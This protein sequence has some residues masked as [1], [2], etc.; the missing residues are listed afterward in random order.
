MDRHGYFL[1]CWY[2]HIFSYMF[3]HKN[4]NGCIDPVLTGCLLY[5]KFTYYNVLQCTTYLSPKKIEKYNPTQEWMV[6][7]L[8]Y[9]FG[10][11]IHGYP[12]ISA[13]FSRFFP[14][15]FRLVAG[16]AA[17]IREVAR[18][19]RTA[20]AMGLVWPP[21][22]SRAGTPKTRQPGGKWGNIDGIYWIYIY[23]N[24]YKLLSHRH[25]YI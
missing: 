21:A 17:F 16:T 9:L 6:F 10:W 4:V 22:S 18:R 5:L 15:F 2:V 8:V 14:C 1:Q 3:F 23:I 25:I 11:L 24:K 13:N 20:S 12:L 7:W 19:K